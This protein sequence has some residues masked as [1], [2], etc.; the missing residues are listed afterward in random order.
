M[1]ENINRHELQTLVHNGAEL[2]EVLG[3]KEYDEAHLP[4]AINIP[5]WKLE[6]KTTAEFNKSQPIIVYCND[7]Q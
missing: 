3:S 7:L 4:G 2:V 1:P 6:R 5:L